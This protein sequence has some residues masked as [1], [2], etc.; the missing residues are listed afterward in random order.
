M[1][2]VLP[3]VLLILTISSCDNKVKSLEDELSSAKNRVSEL[4]EELAELDEEISSN[5]K[6]AF[7]QGALIKW[8][9]DAGREFSIQ[10]P[11]GEFSYQMIDGDYIS[12]NRNGSVSSVGRVYI[13]YNRN[14]SVSS[15]G[16]L[17]ISYD[18]SGR[19]TST[20]GSVY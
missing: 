16:G 18:R 14:G 10:A 7:G 1:N 9:D 13:S 19:V 20:S 5:S 2:Y 8:E 6:E 3:L 11:T 12:Y 17:Y 4:E 15:V